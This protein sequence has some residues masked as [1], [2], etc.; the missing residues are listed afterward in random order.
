MLGSYPC[1]SLRMQES[2]WL[3]YQAL[4]RQGASC[5]SLKNLENE[6]KGMLNLR[7]VF[8]LSFLQ[9]NHFDRIMFY[10]Y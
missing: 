7:K 9:N 10:L 5:H 8:Q 4:R 1:S 2:H 6:K 3:F